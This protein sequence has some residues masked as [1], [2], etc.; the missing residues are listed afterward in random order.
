[1]PFAFFTRPIGKVK[2]R[3]DARRLNAAVLAVLN[4]YGRLAGKDFEATVATW[5]HKPN[6]VIVRKPAGQNPSVE[7]YTIHKIYAYVSKG[8]SIR[9]AT[10]TQDFQPKTRRGVLRSFQGKGGLA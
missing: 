2:P 3:G 7:V 5:D 1:M 10:M 8:T 6:F 9:Y 4:K